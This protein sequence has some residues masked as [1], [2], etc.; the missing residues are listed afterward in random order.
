MNLVARK[1]GVLI[2]VGMMHVALF[3]L[4]ALAQ[5]NGVPSAVCREWDA[6]VNP[7]VRGKIAVKV[8]S[9]SDDEVMVAIGCLLKHRGDQRPAR[10]RGATHYEVSQLLPAASIELASLYYISYLFTGNFQHGDGI[11]FWDQHGVIN[12]PGACEIAYD[13]YSKWFEQVRSMGLAAARKKKLDPL[14]GTNLRWYGK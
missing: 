4:D 7:A 1:C 10:F 8:E 2:A 5:Q 14:Q 11:A 3:S 13:A 9:L 6:K 12:P